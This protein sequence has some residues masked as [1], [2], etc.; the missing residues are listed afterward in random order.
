MIR[1]T[2]VTVYR[3]V[4]AAEPDRFNNVVYG[5]TGED[6]DNVLIA[7]GSTELLE[8][9]RP[10]GVSVSYTLHFPKTYTKS[11]EGCAVALPAP[12]GGTYSVIGD[13]KPYMDANTPTC[14]DRPVEVE[15][16]HG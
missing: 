2:P 7:P 5:L 14:W 9:S 13:P 15:A 10:E 11:L 1:G 12:W 3:K 6:V 16:A 4:A 8:A